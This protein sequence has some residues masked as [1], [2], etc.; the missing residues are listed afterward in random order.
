VEPGR[1]WLRPLIEV[2]RDETTGLV[3][4]AVSLMGAPDC[5]GY[6]FTWRHPSLVTCWLQLKT[7]NPYAAPMLC[8]CFLA[9][10][11]DL[12]LGLGGFDEGLDTWGLEDADLSI[13]IWRA[14]Y[15]CM[16]VPESEIAHLFRQRFPYA[17][18]RAAVVHNALRLAA[19]HFDEPALAKVIRSHAVSSHF[20]A[21]YARLLDSDAWNRR[22]EVA[23]QSRFGGEWFLRRFAISCLG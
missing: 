7:N 20:P 10:R 13:R 4:P 15:R 17:I 21:A 23:S 16:V 14:G 2:L 19:V 1:D 22:L 8:G 5:K 3:A 9:I 12:F 18:D 11:R 6:G